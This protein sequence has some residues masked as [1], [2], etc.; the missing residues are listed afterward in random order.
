MDNRI[1]TICL[2]IFLIVGSVLMSGC[3]SNE[4]Q[5]QPAKQDAPVVSSPVNAS[6]TYIVCCPN[7]KCPLHDPNVKV[8]IDYSGQGTGCRPILMVW[9]DQSREMYYLCQICSDRWHT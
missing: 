5:T 7:P 4:P 3:T 1:K 6:S 2:V 8:H 9:D